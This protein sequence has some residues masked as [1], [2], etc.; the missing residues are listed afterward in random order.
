MSARAPRRSRATREDCIALHAR[1]CEPQPIGRAQT[2]KR[3]R[4]RL[5][6]ERLATFGSFP[7]LAARLA[8]PGDGIRDI[9]LAEIER[10][11]LR[12]HGVRPLDAYRSQDDLTVPGLH[13]EVF[14]RPD[15]IGHALGE[16]ELVF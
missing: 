13:V 15:G 14:R 1:R 5:C 4:P 8:C 7:D 10:G 12:S 11:E 16:G 2:P 3:T 9:L 6:R